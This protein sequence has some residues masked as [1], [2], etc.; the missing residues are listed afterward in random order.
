MAK[1]L[2]NI[3]YQGQVRTCRRVSLNVFE[4]RLS[5]QITLSA[6]IDGS[7]NEIAGIKVEWE[8]KRI[9]LMQRAEEKKQISEN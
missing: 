2:V 4:R 5:T 9:T 7:G 1:Q 3:E 6:S 8:N